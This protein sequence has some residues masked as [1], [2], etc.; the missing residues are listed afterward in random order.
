MVYNPHKPKTPNDRTRVPGQ[1]K[2]YSHSDNLSDLLMI[3]SDKVIKLRKGESDQRIKANLIR[4]ATE[5]LDLY[6]ASGGDTKRS[7]TGQDG[8]MITAED[9]QKQLK[10][11]QGR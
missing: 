9:L 6:F 10:Q 4:I 1:L 8:K 3:V 5:K 2:T 11:Y 7:I